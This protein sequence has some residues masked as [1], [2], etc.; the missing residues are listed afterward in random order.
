ME[1]H[2]LT[3][4]RILLK[5]SGEALLGGQLFGID[6]V[7]CLKTA[8]MLAKLKNIVSEIAVVIGGGNI[9]RGVDLPPE[10]IP[11]T[12]A[13]QIGMLAT[14]LNGI[15]LQETLESV[16][17]PSITLSGLECPRVVESFHWKK[18]NSS[19]V[20]GKILVLVGGTGNPFFTTDTASSMRAAEINADLLIKATKVD[21]VYDKDPL[22]F[23]NAKK[24][25][26]ITFTEVL[27]KN[28]EVL[29]ASAVAMCRKTSIP[30]F[31]CNMKRLYSQDAHL[32]L[33]DLSHGT[34]IA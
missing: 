24:F 3:Y 23:S 4:R 2:R 19:L 30:I 27:E 26:S 33:A 11:R 32:L 6:P 15:A 17:C 21:G 31:V 29:D 7:A 16:G 20:E 9:F 34:L 14:I 18:A 12:S 8:Q 22:K 13:D 5:L 10:Q 28:L 1:R 25:D